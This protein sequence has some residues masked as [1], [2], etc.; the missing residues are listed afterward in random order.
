MKGDAAE[1]CADLLPG[2]ATGHVVGWR[3]WLIK[4]GDRLWSLCLNDVCWPAGE[5]LVAEFR[6]HPQSP[7]YSGIVRAVATTINPIDLAAGIFAFKDRSFASALVLGRPSYWLFGRVALWGDIAEHAH[8][9]RAQYAYPVSLVVPWRMRKVGCRLAERYGCAV[10]RVDWPLMWKAR[11][12]IGRWWN[13][14]KAA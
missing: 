10:E 7:G 11:D 9:Y 1:F 8:G 5:P 13:R 14:A 3:V 4:E 2:N 6:D 12:V